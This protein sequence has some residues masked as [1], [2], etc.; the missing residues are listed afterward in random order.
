MNVQKKK[1][2]WKKVEE[3]EGGI[4]FWFLFLST[5]SS[6]IRLDSFFLYH[7]LFVLSS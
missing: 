6:I 2:K 4:L 7:K 5:G 1:K 3:E